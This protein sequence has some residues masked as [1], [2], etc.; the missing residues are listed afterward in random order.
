MQMCL[1]FLPKGGERR[2]S[3]DGVCMLWK[4]SRRVRTSPLSV[5]TVTSSP[6]VDW[7]LARMKPSLWSGTQHDVLAS[8]G[9]ASSNIFLR[10]SARNWKSGS[11]ANGF[12]NDMAALIGV[13]ERRNDARWWCWKD[14]WP[15]R[16]ARS[17]LLAPGTTES[18]YRIWTSS[19]GSLL[20]GHFIFIPSVARWRM[21]SGHWTGCR[22]N[23]RPP[24]VQVANLIKSFTHKRLWYKPV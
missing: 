14:A 13:R 11:P 17:S 22:F 5:S 6:L 1:Q 21:W 12:V 20:G 10:S 4:L 15:P 18:R 19:D 24:H 16:N 7:M 3:S 9:G 8:Y 23:S 2:N